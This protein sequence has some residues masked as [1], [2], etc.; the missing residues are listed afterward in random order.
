MTVNALRF[1]IGLLVI[2]IVVLS[3][4][5][6]GFIVICV[7]GLI[8][9]LSAIRRRSSFFTTNNGFADTLY[10]RRTQSGTVV[11]SQPIFELLFQ[12]IGCLAK[13]DGTVSQV[14][15]DHTEALIEDLN[16]TPEYRKHAIRCF[17][18]GRD[19]SFN[20]NDAIRQLRNAVDS[21][22]LVGR[23]TFETVC[24]FAVLD[25]LNTAKEDML[26]QFAAAVGISVFH[27][28]DTIAKFARTSDYGAQNRQNQ[29]YSSSDNTERGT[30]RSRSLE[31]A[32]EVLGV[33]STSTNVEM[34][35][36][37]RKLIQECHPDRLVSKGL[38]DFLIEAANAK[39]QEIQE[40]WETVKKA[41]QIA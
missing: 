16:L 2:T 15:I 8:M 11:I 29:R 30:L 9:M 36:T 10:D 40:A 24:E 17:S 26:M 21:E 39:A 27:A 41:R 37:Y 31:D 32:Y 5:A 18:A 4:G 7:I 22:S 14:E 34:K 1:G 28:H 13:A 6:A 12:F 20:V 35:N 3:T 25:G 38:P 23:I 33:D 19:I